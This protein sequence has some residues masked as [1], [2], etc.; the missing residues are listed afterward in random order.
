LD[1]ARNEITVRDGKGQKDRITM[2]PEVLKEPLMRHLQRVRKI[3]ERDLQ[4]GA[5]RAP[6][7]DAI[8]R[9]YPNASRECGWPWVFPASSLYFD[10]EAGM[11]RRHHLHESV[12][13]KLMKQAVK[14]QELQNRQVATRCGTALQPIFWKQVTT[15]GPSRN[16]W[17]TAMSAR[18]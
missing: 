2:F 7:P 15:Y 1:F 16:C 12:I 14:E 9:K 3:H 13:Q 4:Q 17:V 8:E 6:L 10:S 11:E 5:G 18:P